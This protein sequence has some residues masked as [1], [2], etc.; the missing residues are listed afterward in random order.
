MLYIQT[1]Q[2]CLQHLQQTVGM[3]QFALSFF[4][5]LLVVL[6]AQLLTQLILLLL[7]IALA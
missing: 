6:A 2:V 7:T 5:L 4:Q 3:S 1:V